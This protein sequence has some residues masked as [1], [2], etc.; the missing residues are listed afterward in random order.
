MTTYSRRTFLSHVAALGALRVSGKSIFTL[1]RP[2]V[3]N[4]T[5]TFSKWKEG[6]LDIHHICTG[7]G[8]STFIICPDG[9]TMLIDAGDNNYKGSIM[10]AVPNEN[11]SPGEW[12]SDY[13]RRF[14]QPLKN[15]KTSLDYAFL[16]HFHSDH[17]GRNRNDVP[18]PHGYA[19]SGISMVAEQMDI[20][21]IVDRG[22]PNYDFPSQKA[23]INE[24]VDN[25]IKFVKY[26]QQE[27]KTIIEGFEAGSKKQ[28]VLQNKPEKYPDF[29]IRNIYVNGEVWT[30]EGTNTKVIHPA[31]ANPDE[32]MCSGV[33][34][35]TYGSFSYYSG[36]D[37]IGAIG[38]DV[39]THIA[40]R[41][42]PV[43]AMIMNHHAQR[44]ATNS[45]FLGKLSPRVMVIPVWHFEH[46]HPET[47]AR[48]TDKT[49]YPGDRDIFVTG[50]FKGLSDNLGEAVNVIK[51][52]G[53]I[54]IRVYAKGKKYQVFVLNAESEK[55]EV[56]YVTDYIPSKKQP[57][58]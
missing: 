14:S 32:N 57:Y 8:N 51:P 16:T 48:M 21:K 31:S 6:W 19:L 1:G 23:V 40:D 28:F 58:R 9:T 52:Y 41:V 3:T 46:P 43:D 54:V 17:I 33:I 12:I 29:N 50:M 36:G 34:K 37:S 53:H 2:D 20:K 24:N 39:E 5:K 38:R 25:Y 13:I 44:D 10:S 26:R 7:R 56:K 42:G 27:K 30:G 11:K 4:E 18:R 49:I 47:L 22:Y 15:E 35:L 45:Y 55:F